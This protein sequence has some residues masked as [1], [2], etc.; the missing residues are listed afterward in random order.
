MRP[1]SPIAGPQRHSL[2]SLARRRQRPGSHQSACFAA[3][4]TAIRSQT[5]QFPLARSQNPMSIAE[6]TAATASILSRKS[7]PAAKIPIAPAAPPLHHPPRFR[8]LALLGR[9]RPEHVESSSSRRPRNLHISGSRKLVNSAEECRRAVT[10][11]CLRAVPR[12]EGLRDIS[13]GS[14]DCS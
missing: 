5:V 4:H 12:R 14:A 2:F 11:V 3:Y 9:R 13:P 8:A 7:D 6:P 1:S 10:T